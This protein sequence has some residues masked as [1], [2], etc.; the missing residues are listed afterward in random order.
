MIFSDT[1]GAMHTSSRSC[2]RICSTK[3]RISTRKKRHGMQE[4]RDATMAKGTPKVMERDAQGQQQSTKQKATSPHW[5]S[6]IQRKESYHH[7]NSC[8]Y[9]IILLIWK[10]PQVNLAQI[11]IYIWFA[12]PRGMILLTVPPCLSRYFHFTPQSVL[13]DMCLRVGHQPW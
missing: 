12:G 7:Q 3:M 6:M 1:Q 9:F 8:W 11:L 10:L 5:T 2:W 4:I 13:S